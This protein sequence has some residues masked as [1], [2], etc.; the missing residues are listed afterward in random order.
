[1]LEADIQRRLSRLNLDTAFTVAAGE[2][3]ARLDPNGS[4]KSTTLRAL[5]GLLP[6]AGGRVVLDGTV[7]HWAWPSTGRAALRTVPG[8]CSSLTRPVAG[9]CPAARH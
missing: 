6:L 8:L 7:L 4:G 2:V 5:M 1:M 3:L 9:S